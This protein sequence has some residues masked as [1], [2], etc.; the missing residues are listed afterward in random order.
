MDELPDD[1]PLVDDVLEV[2]EEGLPGGVAP[3]DELLVVDE[4][5][6]GEPDEDE[7]EVAGPDPDECPPTSEPLLDEE[8]PPTSIG[9]RPISSGFSPHPETPTTHQRHPADASNLIR[10]AYFIANHLAQPATN[11]AVPN[12]KQTVPGIVSS[13]FLVI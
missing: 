13:T 3:D 8:D 11:V 5:E 9:P 4:P 12:R 7:L 1:E 10:H 6:D 2:P